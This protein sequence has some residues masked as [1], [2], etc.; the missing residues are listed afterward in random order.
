MKNILQPRGLVK[1]ELSATSRL[2]SKLIIIY[3]LKNFGKLSQDLNLKDNSQ[4]VYIG[5]ST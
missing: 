4:I 1:M 3:F 5:S 2:A